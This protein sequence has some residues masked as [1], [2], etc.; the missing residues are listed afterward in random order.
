MCG[1]FSLFDSIDDLHSYF[2]LAVQRT[3]RELPPRYNIAPSQQVAAIRVEEGE[4]RLVLLRWGLIPHWADD[5]KIAFRTINA[6]AE[7]AATSP[8]FRAAFRARR[9]L[10]P[11]SGF[12]EWDRKG[13]TK[14]PFAIARADGAPLALAGLWE[15]WEGDAGRSVIESCTILTIA[16]NPDL[17]KLHDRMPVL[18]E[19]DDFDLW[20]DPD[21]RRPEQLRPLLRP[22]PPGTLTLRP[23]SRYVNQA[24][25]EGPECLAPP[26]EERPPAEP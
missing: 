9:C 12:Y 24:A 20:L 16:A 22:A 1:R 4:R 14:E 21:V 15:H 19:P 23:V 3:L 13:G 2:K 6:R 25:H 18:L 8:A 26:E 10:I 7:T 17:E 5:P 11:A